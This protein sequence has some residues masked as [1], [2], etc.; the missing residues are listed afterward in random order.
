VKICSQPYE[1][2]SPTVHDPYGMSGFRLIR[3]ITIR[4]EEQTYNTKYLF[5]IELTVI[6][7]FP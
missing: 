4:Y 3:T 2:A 7:F 6:L 5:Y 1:V